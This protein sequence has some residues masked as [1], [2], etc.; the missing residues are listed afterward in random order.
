[1]ENSYFHLL[2]TLTTEKTLSFPIDL[3]LK[4]GFKILIHPIGGDIHFIHKKNSKKE[5]L[6]LLDKIKNTLS[7]S[8]SKL[9][10]VSADPEITLNDLG[11]FGVPNSFSLTKR[12]KHH[13]DPVGVFFAPYY[14]FGI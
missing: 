1:M 4:E 5:Q 7:N 11:S 6:K 9:R 2:A 8:E 14:D 13:L 10:W 3:F 12:L